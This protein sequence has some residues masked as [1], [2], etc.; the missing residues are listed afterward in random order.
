MPFLM[1]GTKEDIGEGVRR[2]GARLA[3]E[4]GVEHVAVVSSQ[5][6]KGEGVISWRGGG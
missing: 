1:V 5:L 6:G 2:Q 3:S 4:L